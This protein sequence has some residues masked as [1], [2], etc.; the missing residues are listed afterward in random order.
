MTVVVR[1]LNVYPVKSA[2][3]TPLTGAEVLPEG[4]R[5]D[6]AFML[7]R[8]DGRHLSQRE[9]PRMALLR[10]SYDGVKLAVEF[11]GTG[12][13]G[14]LVHS[15]S[16][17]GPVLDVT[18]HGNPCQ[19]VDQGDEAAGWFTAALGRECRL[20]RFTGRRPTRV[21]GGTVKFADEFPLLVTSVESLEELNSRLD[22]P[23]PMNRFRPNI[24]LE[25]LGAWGEDT[26][27]TL[28]IGGVEL[29]LVK[30]CARCVITTTDQETAVK[31]REPLRTLATYRTL[32]FPDGDRGVIFGQNAV[33]RALGTINV[34]DAVEVTRDH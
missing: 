8:P 14:P 25:G 16:G 1:E 26:V 10:P 6:R 18:V 27:R 12:P 17:D 2:G 19:G 31:G 24:V 20:V 30:P 28:R 3:G 34:G 5:N 21:G 32:V 4:F 22:E 7:V 33:P 11:A 29:E 13:D 9:V 15:V 23:L